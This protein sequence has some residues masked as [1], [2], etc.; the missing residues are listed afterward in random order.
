MASYYDLLGVTADAGD[1]ELRRAYLARAQLLHPDRHTGS[2]EAV[3]RQAEAEMK[4]V[5]EAWNTLKDPEARQRYD[6]AL[7]LAWAEEQPPSPPSFFRRAGV[8]LAIVALIVAGLVG[9]L[10]AAV[11]SGGSGPASPAEPVADRWTPAAESELRTAAIDAGFTSTQADCFTRYIT[12]RFSPSD[13]VD[14]S[15]VDEAAASCR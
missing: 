3:R 13:E 1:E 15:D 12:S 6:L 2:P 9:S 4:A 7:D 14:R 11:V 5:N 8:Q 10:V